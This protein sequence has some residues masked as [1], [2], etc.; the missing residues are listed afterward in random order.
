[1]K[2]FVEWKYVQTGAIYRL[3]FGAAG[4]LRPEKAGVLLILVCLL[5]FG[6]ISIGRDDFN[7]YNTYT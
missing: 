2:P 7:S 1:M 3:N 4:V 5:K 6:H